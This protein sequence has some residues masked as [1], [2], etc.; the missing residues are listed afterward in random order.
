[1]EAAVPENDGRPGLV[2]P[3]GAENVEQHINIVKA[4]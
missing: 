3:N 2:F 1:M 4:G